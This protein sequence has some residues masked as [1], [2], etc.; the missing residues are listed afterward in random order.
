MVDG[1]QRSY[2]TVNQPL[3]AALTVKVSTRAVGEH[4]AEVDVNDA[5]SSVQQDVPVVSIFD[6]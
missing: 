1:K 3:L 6:L 2:A 5:T 4:E